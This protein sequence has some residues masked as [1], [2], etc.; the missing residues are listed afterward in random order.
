MNVNGDKG[1]IDSGRIGLYGIWESDKN[2]YINSVI[3]YGHHRFKADR[4]MT[5][6][7]AIAHNK[8]NGHHLS[9]LTELGR[10]WE[11]Y[12]GYIF[13]HYVSVACLWLHE[14]GYRETNAGSQN[15][16]IKNHRSTTVQGKNGMQLAH[17]WKWNDSSDVYTFIRLGLTYRKTAGKNQKTSAQLI[18]QGGLFSVYS[19]NRR[20]ILINPGIGTTV[21]FEKNLKTT[22]SYEADVNSHQKNHSALIRLSYDF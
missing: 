2:W 17:L 1:N 13:T 9:G 11:F 18:D 3:Y 10:D 8:H 20:K 15:L 4:V 5:T 21:L 12:R 19:R 7:P 14:N 16:S 6:I 22:L